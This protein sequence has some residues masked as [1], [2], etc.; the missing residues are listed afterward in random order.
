MEVTEMNIPGFTAETSLYQTK[1]H[2]RLTAGGSLLS[3]GNANVV[4][5]DCRWWLEEP[6]CATFMAAGALACTAT[7]AGEIGTGS[8][9]GLPG[10]WACWK[11][12][13]GASFWLCNDCIK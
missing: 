5:Q 9:L 11:L 2:Y 12:V 1:N 13:T 10:C 8:A 7:C 3:Y 4:P 6:A